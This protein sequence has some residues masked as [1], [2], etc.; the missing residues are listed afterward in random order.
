MIYVT[1][2][3]ILI[4][5]II[6]F[7]FIEHIILKPKSPQEPF[8]GDQ[9]Q[10][11]I[12]GLQEKYAPIIA[13]L[14]QKIPIAFGIYK[15][16]LIPSNVIPNKISTNTCALSAVQTFFMQPDPKLFMTVS[17]EEAKNE[18]SQNNL[19][20]IIDQTSDEITKIQNNVVY[21]F[22][23]YHY[24]LVPGPMGPMGPPGPMGDIGPAGMTGETGEPGLYG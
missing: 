24:P 6:L 22:D 21:S 4:A 7:L 10:Y 11:T 14:N 9:S 2:V 18:V 3:G 16:Y 17:R 23:I 5:A 15:N 8:N 20:F 13:D 12:E 19:L 1:V